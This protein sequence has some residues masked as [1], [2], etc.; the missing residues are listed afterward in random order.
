MTALLTP[1]KLFKMAIIL[2]LG[3]PLLYLLARLVEARA[4][5]HYNRHTARL[6]KK[7]ILF[8]GAAILSVDLLRELDLKMTALLGSAGVAG[9]AIGFAF[10][11]S[12]SNII[13]GIFI[14]LEAPFGVGDFIEVGAQKGTVASFDLLAVKVCSPENNF[15]R[16]PNEQ[17]LNQSV[18]NHT[19]FPVKRISLGVSFSYSNDQE[20]VAVL[21]RKVIQ[22]NDYTLAAPAP[23]ITF[24]EFADSA[25][26]CLLKIWVKTEDFW[27]AKNSLA[28]Q[29]HQAFQE[30]EISMPF[31]H[32]TL[33][34]GADSG[35]IQVTLVDHSTRADQ[36]P[37]TPS[38]EES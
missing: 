30:A 37:V 29:V 20:E 5:D 19:R 4:V 7:S 11:T 18:I 14:S 36:L 2:L 1:E 16:I 21:L 34:H 38:Q 31:P 33:T 13:S 12:I 15:I 26:S 8:L 17:L 28:H 25:I 6:L 10:K 3:Y 22:A 27:E 23:K 24:T 35:P 32:L 9:M